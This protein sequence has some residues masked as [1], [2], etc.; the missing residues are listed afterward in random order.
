M[1]PHHFNNLLAKKKFTNGSDLS[2]VQ[3]KYAKIFA[4]TVGSVRKLRFDLLGWGCDEIELLC[5]SLPHFSRLASLDLSGNRIGSRGFVALAELLKRDATENI[6]PY[7]V[8]LDI[9]DNVGVWIDKACRSRLRHA[10]LAAGKPATGL[11]LLSVTISKW[12]KPMD[13]WLPMVA[14]PF[15]V[16]VMLVIGLDELEHVPTGTTE[17]CLVAFVFVCEVCL[18]VWRYRARPE[19]RANPQLYEA[20]PGHATPAAVEHVS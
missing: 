8:N 15:F 6:L 16:C 14:V 4:Q 5:E 17:I 10:W 3:G 18:G 2:L 9:S 7:L 11:H 1:P 19:H 20:C 13:F 12:V